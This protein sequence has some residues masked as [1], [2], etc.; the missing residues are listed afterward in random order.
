MVDDCALLSILMAAN[1]KAKP[2]LHDARFP[3]ESSGYREARNQLLEAEIELRR[4]I[5]EVAAL[6]RKLPLGGAV[7]VDY[8]FTE[9]AVN[10][11]DLQSVRN[12]KLSEIFPRRKC[13]PCD[14]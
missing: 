5:E 6:R 7:P 12:V 8:E 11:N 14:L 1:A 13:Q 3:G 4:R 10:L 9:G 2:E